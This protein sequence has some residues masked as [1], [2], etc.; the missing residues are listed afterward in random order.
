MRAESSEI[1]KSLGHDL[2]KLRSL[3]KIIFDQKMTPRDEKRKNKF[4]LLSSFR[5]EFLKKRKMTPELIRPCLF[6]QSFQAFNYVQRAIQSNKL[7]TLEF[8][9]KGKGSPEMAKIKS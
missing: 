2:K 8:S 7:F 5:N 1:R 3:Y 4:L 6:L 9:I